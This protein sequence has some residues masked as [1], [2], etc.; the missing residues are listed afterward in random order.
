MRRHAEIGFLHD[1][2]RDDGGRLAVGDER[3]VVQD[4]DAVGERAHHV[5]LVLDEEDGPVAAGLQVVDQLEHRRH[6]VD[7]HAGGRLVEHE[8]L[9]LERDEQRHFELALVPVRERLRGH[10][11]LVGQADPLEDGLGLLD[12]VAPAVPDG[13]QG[14]ACLRPALHGEPHVLE[15]GELRKQIGELK[16][17]PEPLAGPLRTRRGR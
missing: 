3:A 8:D 4:D 5:H 14:P 9:R 1:G 7:A 13:E 17:A 15:R 16:G 12:E 6:L 11:S 2:R 10:V